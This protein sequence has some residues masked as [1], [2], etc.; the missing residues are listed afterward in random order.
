MILW[1]KRILL[2]EFKNAL[3]VLNNGVTMKVPPVKHKTLSDSSWYAIAVSLLVLL[4]VTG[5]YALIRQQKYFILRE[6]ADEIATI[7]DLK[8]SQL[9]QWRKERFAE[10]ASIR[11]NGMISSHIY[12][13]LSGRNRVDV[14][15]EF[16]HW[17]NSLIDLGEYSKGTLFRPTGEIIASDSAFTLP[18]ASHY[19]E[20]ISEAARDG[21]LILSDFH[22]DTPGVPYDINL[23]IPI[24]YS[25]GPDNRCIAVLILEIDPTKRLYPLIKSWPT[26]SS[27]AET[28]LVKRE[29]NNV[30]FLNDLRFATNASG[31]LVLPLSQKALPAARAALG[32]E[33]DF[34][35][36]DYRGISVLSAVR[37]IPG[38]RWGM[39]TKI[40]VSEALEPLSDTILMVTSLG[41]VMIVAIILGIYLWGT[42]R[43]A[44]TL[45][46]LVEIEQ[47][48][49]SELMKSEESLTRSR[50]YHQKLLEVFPSLIWR[51]GVDA[52]CNYFNQTWL[53]FTGHTFEEEIG[54]GWMNGVHP[55][56]L[57]RCRSTY[58]EAFQA[59]RSFE[60]EYRLR[61]NDGSY[62]WIRDHGCPYDNPE[63]DFNGYIGSGYD[64]TD[65]KNAEHEL[66]NVHTH[67]EHQILERTDDLSMINS[68]LRQ[69]IAEREK[70]EQK[71]L[72]AK[73]LEAIGQIAG[74]V[75][76]EVRNPLNA[77]LTITEAL[78]REREIE[79]NPEFK[80]YIHHIRTQVKRLVHLMNDLL[81]LGRTIPTTNLQP[82]SLYELCRESL[83]LW[84]STGS[85]PSRKGVLTSDNDDISFQIMVDGPKFQQVLFNLLEN[86]G[87]H[88]SADGKILIQ[89]THNRTEPH[90]GMA[91][92]RVIDSGAGIAEERLPFVFDPFYTDRKGGTGLGLALVRHFVENMD[93]NVRIWNNSPS[94]G[95]T[96]EVRIPLVRK[97]QQ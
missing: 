9:V 39:V 26:A 85:S 40:D 17:L 56:D 20:L 66:R 57:E 96:V 80:P 19:F 59:R 25:S 1:T 61:F 73:R 58:L 78:F 15:Q 95:C 62:R 30:V 70:L 74:G 77:I 93:G 68:L 87:W 67:L 94:P 22:Q 29:S 53:A 8:A 60:I 38:T 34:R 71:L 52:R 28:L 14:R 31:P 7:A 33:G 42:R 6:K 89:M 47:K 24:M 51:S 23:A 2:T 82:M 41:S 50:D 84:K 43:K 10:G 75:A 72:N 97:G 48:H 86:A 16:K 27:T 92:I 81:D 12:D 44:E 91:V 5:G 36:T 88:S 49:N 76:H 18:A 64:I 63:G 69:E 65:Q 83:D 11:A 79:G 21:E 45:E 90:D 46:R 13:H 3:T 35:G 37:V 54:D 32:L 4:I 55:E